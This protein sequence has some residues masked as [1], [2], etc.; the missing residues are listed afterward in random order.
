MRQTSSCDVAVF[1][2]GLAMAFLALAVPLLPSIL[3]ISALFV[4]YVVV[5]SPSVVN[6][7]FMFSVT[8]GAH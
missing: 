5:H 7:W 8:V 3:G 1:S 2:Y 6:L 4:R